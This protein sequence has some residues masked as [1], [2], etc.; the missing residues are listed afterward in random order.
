MDAG[1]RKNDGQE[2]LADV[3]VLEG[4]LQAL[5]SG[6]SVELPPFEREKRIDPVAQEQTLAAR[7]SPELVHASNPG[8]GID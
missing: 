1:R 3:R 7:K 5:K 4:I 8:R 2:G 6:A